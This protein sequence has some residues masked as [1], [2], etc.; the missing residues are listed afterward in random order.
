MTYLPEETRY[1]SARGRRRRRECYH[2]WTVTGMC[3]QPGCGK[4][5]AEVADP[6]DPRFTKHTSF[7][8]EQ[9]FGRPRETGEDDGQAARVDEEQPT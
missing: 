5:R 4:T 6:D 9:R 2:R 1:R 7:T 3:A 8:E